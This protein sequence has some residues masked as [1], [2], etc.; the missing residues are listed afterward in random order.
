MTYIDSYYSR[1][2][3]PAL[4]AE[5]LSEQI[6]TPVCIVGGGLAGISTALGLAERGISCV[7]LES[8]QAGWGASGRNGGFLGRGFS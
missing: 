7:L 1:T 3:Q 2:A 5:A 8:R 4:Q 6:E